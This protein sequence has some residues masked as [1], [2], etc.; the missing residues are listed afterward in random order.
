MREQKIQEQT[1]IKKIRTLPP[2]SVAE[3]EN[4]VDFLRQRSEDQRLTQAEAKLSENCQ[5]TCWAICNSET[6]RLL[7][8]YL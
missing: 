2:E 8:G 5:M 1:L 3:V 4:F 7:N 6:L